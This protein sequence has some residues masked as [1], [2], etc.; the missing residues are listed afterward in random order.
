MDLSIF[1]D[2]RQSTIEKDR[3]RKSKVHV[4]LALGLGLG[5]EFGKG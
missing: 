5:L 3:M 2:K 4:G 1:I